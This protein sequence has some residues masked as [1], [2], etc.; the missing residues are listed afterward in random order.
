M[1]YI[2]WSR[3][4]LSSLSLKFDQKNFF[5]F[6]FFTLKFPKFYNN[7]H[8]NLYLYQKRIEKNIYIPSLDITVWVQRESFSQQRAKIWKFENKKKFWFFFLFFFFFNKKNL[9]QFFENQQRE[10]GHMIAPIKSLGL[11][12]FCIQGCNIVSDKVNLSSGSYLSN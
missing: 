12:Y 5:F 9:Q 1:I 4:C 10:E 3:H 8:C 11:A 2:D 6:I 7:L